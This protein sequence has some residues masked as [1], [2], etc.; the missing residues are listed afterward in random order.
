MNGPDLSDVYVLDINPDDEY[1]Y[2]FD[3]EWKDLEVVPTYSSGVQ[4]QTWRITMK[5]SG[6]MKA[7]VEVKELPERHVAY[8][9]H[10][11]PYAGNGALFEDLFGRLCR[12]AGPRGLLGR[13]DGIEQLRQLLDRPF[14]TTD[15]AARSAL[16]NLKTDAALALAEIGSDEAV[17][18]VASN[19]GD[20]DNY[21]ESFTG[22]SASHPCAGGEVFIRNLD[23]FKED[24][25]E[26][27]FHMR[28]G[29]A[30]GSQTHS[31]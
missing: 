16:E 22:A 6:T 8:V 28:P 9:R 18:I 19:T 4:S 21:A 14:P 26:Y 15:A 20:L 27:P 5:D 2:K 17:E 29:Q 24:W 10:V 13:P 11:G 3:G 30:T 25:S 1:Q 7:E 31:G 23:S 12:W